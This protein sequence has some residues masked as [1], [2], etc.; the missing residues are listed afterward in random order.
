MAVANGGCSTHDLAAPGSACE[1]RDAR[2]RTVRRA[3]T[4]PST[5]PASYDAAEHDAAEHDAA[6]HDAGGLRCRRATTQR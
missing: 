2:Q 5:R 6:E 3:T 1:W 4:P